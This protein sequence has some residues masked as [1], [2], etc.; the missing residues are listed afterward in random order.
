M[1]LFRV[2]SSEARLGPTAFFAE[3]AASAIKETR[4]AIMAAAMTTSETQRFEVMRD[5]IAFLKF[6]TAM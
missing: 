6:R 3:S 1:A 5:F 2:A 4:P